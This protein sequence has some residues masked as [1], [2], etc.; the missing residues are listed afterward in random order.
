MYVP[1][2]QLLPSEVKAIEKLSDALFGHIIPLVELPTIDD[3]SQSLAKRLTNSWSGEFFLDVNPWYSSLER[4][5]DHKKTLMAIM[6]MA[7]GGNAIPVP[8]VY[9]SDEISFLLSVSKLI[10]HGNGSVVLR[11]I[12]EDFEN[13][14]TLRGNVSRVVKA[15]DISTDKIVIVYDTADLVR[16]CEV[17]EVARLIAQAHEVLCDYAN[18]REH[19]VHSSCLL[20]DNSEYKAGSVNAVQ[21]K[22][23]L[24][25][26]LCRQQFRVSPTFSDRTFLQPVPP[27]RTNQPIAAS[28]TVRYSSDDTVLIYRGHSL[29]IEKHGRYEQYI[30][31]AMAIVKHP[32]FKGEEYSF[33]DREIAKYALREMKKDGKLVTGNPST[34]RIALINH[35]LTLTARQFYT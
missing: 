18:W 19:V 16:S 20:N 13:L 31:H 27:L 15:L 12:R 33:G 11:M 9:M 35:H 32:E 17:G 28:A 4:T 5:I 30:D 23:V 7:R 24:L 34:W 3:K 14:E 2:L 25:F 1:I 8:V 6:T 10:K 21:R 29:K 22:E 26:K